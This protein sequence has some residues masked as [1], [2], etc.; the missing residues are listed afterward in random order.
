MV[1]KER[2]G[3]GA[4]IG[5]SS[6]PFFGALC[7]MRMHWIAAHQTM[8]VAA[9]IFEKKTQFMGVYGYQLDV[10]ALDTTMDG[11]QPVVT[12]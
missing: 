2:E 1:L 6:L 8:H 10:I 9:G 5:A 3:E 11:H 4:K 7:R 12:D